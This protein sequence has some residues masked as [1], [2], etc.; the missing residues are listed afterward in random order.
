MTRNQLKHISRVFW[1]NLWYIFLN[2]KHK[3]STE[4]N[5]IF[6]EFWNFE[7]L[8]NLIFCSIQF[9]N[10]FF[11][12]FFLLLYWIKQRSMFWNRIFYIVCWGTAAERR[13]GK[14]WQLAW[15]S[16]QKEIICLIES[17]TRPSYQHQAKHN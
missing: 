2:H 14:I 12:S 15:Y 7:F 6:F 10:P 11:F 1:S 13:I 16:G 4:D 3:A 9:I 8:K 17:S 5:Q